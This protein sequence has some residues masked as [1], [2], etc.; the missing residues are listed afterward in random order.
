MKIKPPLFSC[1]ILLMVCINGQRMAAQS[2]PA[3]QNEI[4]V[5]QTGVK[6]E[7]LNL[8]DKTRHRAVPVVLY[9]P[10][11]VMNAGY[12]KRPKLK[13]AIINHGY[14]G[15]NTDYSFIANNLVKHGY[16]VA[17]IQHQLP[18]DEPLPT[19]GNPYEARKPNWERG[20]RNILFVI[21]ELKVMRPE[22]DFGALLL[23]GH[24]NGGDTIMLFAREHPAMVREVISLDNRR[25]P[26]PRTGRPRVLSLRSSDQP[27]DAGVLPSPEEQ[28][29]LGIK[30]IRL[31]NTKH[32]DMWDGATEKQKLEINELINSFLEG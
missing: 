1:L 25:M 12:G 3:K 31:K 16:F 29:R 11:G 6:T 5:N 15:K 13:L 24:S 2:V 23:L 9:S 19:T 17:S 4:V 22:L 21:R 7:T 10:G 20:V 18:S 26:L 14:G 28:E 8:F 27:A 32:D 30:I